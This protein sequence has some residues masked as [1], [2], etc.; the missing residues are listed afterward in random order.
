MGSPK[1]KQ[2]L[3]EVLD[4]MIRKLEERLR[5]LKAE[6]N[7][8]QPE[9]EQQK[10]E[11]YSLSRQIDYFKSTKKEFEE[12]LAREK[13]EEGRRKLE[14]V[15]KAAI[16]LGSIAENHRIM[17]QQLKGTESKAGFLGSFSD[18]LDRIFTSGR[19]R[20]VSREDVEEILADR[21]FQEMAELDPHRLDREAE[22]MKAEC[23]RMMTVALHQ[24]GIETEDDF[25]KTEAH[26]RRYLEENNGYQKALDRVEDFTQHELQEIG[27]REDKAFFR[28]VMGEI[29]ELSAVTQ[30]IAAE[31][32]AGNAGFAQGHGYTGELIE[33][34]KRLVARLTAYGDARMEEILSMGPEDPKTRDGIRVYQ[35]VQ[36]LLGPIRQQVE[37]DSVMERN[38]RLRER[39]ERWDVYRNL[40]AANVQETEAR[41]ELCRRA[42]AKL[43]RLERMAVRAGLAYT[44]ELPDEELEQRRAALREGKGDVIAV[45]SSW[46]AE[47]T[48]ELLESLEPEEPMKDAE[49]AAAKRRLAMLVVHQILVDEGRNRDGQ[50]KPYTDYLNAH[51]NKLDFMGLADSL[52][53]TAEF[54]QVM[55]G[56]LNGQDG[57]EAILRFLAEDTEKHA[58][59]RLI[60]LKVQPNAL[61]KE[62]EL[63]NLVRRQASGRG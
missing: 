8:D 57:K 34:E 58:A 33:R 40:N 62:K 63:R 48:Q 56:L 51:R 9:S 19:Y 54:R 47:E 12:Q 43:R 5:S 23:Q 27:T 1:K 44:R 16:L 10:A 2:Q 7:K 36:M 14:N 60:T 50:P 18:M 55:D 45:T 30:E 61:K 42:G 32:I 4:D 11:R 25:D 31:Y 41:K 17:M 37:R 29:R 24:V 15:L 3:L 6:G 39:M 21:E 20:Y 26:F 38:D 22:D 35:N 49:L 53:E 59:R 13:T 46:T 28:E 52:A